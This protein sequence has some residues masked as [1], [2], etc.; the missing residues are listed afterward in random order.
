MSK[1]DQNALLW[2]MLDRLLAQKN[3]PKDERPDKRNEL[4]LLLKDVF[5]VHSYSKLTKYEKWL[6]Y[7]KCE[8]MLARDF[9]YI[10]FD[11]NESELIFEDENIQN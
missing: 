4:F 8:V 6:F 3:V 2:R 1:G 5:N 7:Q 11:L 9:G 10:S